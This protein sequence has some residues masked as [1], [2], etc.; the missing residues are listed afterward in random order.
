[1][2]TVKQILEHINY[3]NDENHI[4]SGLS[5]LAEYGLLDESKLPLIK[6][7]LTK[8]NINEMTEAERKILLESL[9]TIV[10][11]ITEAKRD[12]LTTFDKRIPQGYPSDKEA[13]PVLILKRKAIRVYPDNQKVALYY[14]QALDKHISIPFGNN[15]DTAGIQISESKKIG[16]AHV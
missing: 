4:V 1:M 3:T 9:N 12:H 7:A 11:E 16:R 2:K 5:Q 13:P 6:R 8:S 14:S 10:D 15:S